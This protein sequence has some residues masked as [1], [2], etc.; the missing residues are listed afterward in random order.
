MLVLFKMLAYLSCLFLFAQVESSRPFIS[1]NNPPSNNVVYIPPRNREEEVYRMITFRSFPVCA[2]TNSIADL[3][4]VGF[5]YTGFEARCVCFSCDNIV[6]NWPPDI[7]VR[8][9]ALR[10]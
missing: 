9:S 8:S 1:V 3:A 6:E 5:W 2:V 4:F 10:L 7:D